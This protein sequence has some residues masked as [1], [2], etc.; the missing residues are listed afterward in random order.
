MRFVRRRLWTRYATVAFAGLLLVACWLHLNRGRFTRDQYDR[1]HIGMT[2]TQVLAIIA[3]EPSEW[4]VEAE[5]AR[6]G[7]WMT[8]ASTDNWMNRPI[9]PTDGVWKNT[10]WSDGYVM[11][12][13]VLKD[14]IVTD[15]QLNRY[16][17]A[18]RVWASRCID[19]SRNVVVR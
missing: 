8:E 13:V 12:D 15:K 14:G 17:P 2:E 3:H 1:I 6:G 7:T 10:C 5:T 4:N 16:V 19:R 11:I 18:W 9:P